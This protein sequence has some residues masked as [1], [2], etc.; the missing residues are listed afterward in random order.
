M[1]IAIA[2]Y[3]GSEPATL[4]EVKSNIAKETLDLFKKHKKPR[5]IICVGRRCEYADN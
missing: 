3:D 4:E 1:I 2:T 5:L